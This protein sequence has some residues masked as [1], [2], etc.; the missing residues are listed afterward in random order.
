MRTVTRTSARGAW[1]NRN[2]R[3][4]WTGAGFSLLG[5]EMGEIAIP[6]LA[7][8]TLE[9]SPT[10]M[11]LLRT[12]QFLPFL[13]FTLWV[14]VLVDR[15][16]RRP[17][18]I[19][20]D[21]VRGLVLL[22]VP[23]LLAAGLLPVGGLI[24]LVFLVGTLT[25]VYQLADFSFLPSVVAPDQLADA[26]AK[27][28]ATQ[29]TMTIAGGGIGGAVVQFLTAPVAV[30]VNAVS[31]LGSA[32]C[33]GRTAVV[34]EIPERRQNCSLW[35][36]T[37]DGVRY[38]LGNRA[39]RALAGEA[40]TW[41][42]SNEIFMLGLT[43]HVV[44]TLDLGPAMLGLILV[45]G[46]IGGFL[47]AWFS[48]WA[49]RTFGYGHAVL[50]TMLLGNTAPVAVVLCRDDPAV[51]LAVYC[52]VFLVAGIG[53]GVANAQSNTVRQLS[54]PDALRGRVNSAYRLLSWGALAIGAILAG[55]IVTAL[56][57]YLATIIGSVG[58]AI[59]TLWIVFSPVPR[60]TD[61]T[62]AAAYAR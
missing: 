26:N 55:V 44:S 61:H 46:G 58:V 30:A 23:V 39:V 10:E 31:Y 62:D 18:L 45:T 59:S 38:L 47:G 1:T 20:S 22:A 15:M 48:G 37:R 4:L 32:W 2:F 54:T 51:S 27:L 5:S 21:L 7:L 14:G 13:L 49:T 24:A 6:L 28:S 25:V 17:L 56:N 36:Q 33:L 57:P 29:S 34:E 12:A 9:A 11:S 52:A 16:R 43:L 50:T 41:N 35:A 3:W 40:A 8:L 60:M 42:L 19:G 53:S